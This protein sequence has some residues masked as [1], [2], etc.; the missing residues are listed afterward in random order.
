ML[1]AIKLS[2][3]KDKI[4]PYQAVTED[5]H[6]KTLKFESGIDTCKN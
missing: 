4:P 5:S 6:G 3:N 1:I 2:E